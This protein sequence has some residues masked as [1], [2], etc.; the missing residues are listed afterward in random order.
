M[1]NEKI[2]TELMQV[3]SDLLFHDLICQE[4][5]R[6][7]EWIIM[8][9]LGCSY[10]D[11]HD[12]VKVGNVRLTRIDDKD[13]SKYIDLMLEYNNYK[14][15]FELNNSFRGIYTRNNIYAG[16]VLINNYKLNDDK[17]L[18]DNYYRKVVKIILINLNWHATEIMKENIPSKKEF[19]LPYNELDDKDY[20][21]KIININLDYYDKICYDDVDECDKFYKLL[22]V[23]SKEEMYNIMQKEKM[24][25]YYGNKIIELS[26]NPKYK[27]DIMYRM[28]QIIEDNVGIQTSYLEGKNVGILEGRK[29]GFEQGIEQGIEKN[30]KETI[31]NMLADKLPLETIS[32]YVGLSIKEIKSMML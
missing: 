30:K 32:K 14:V 5:K 20:L 7:I 9:V 12:K 21:V 8:H 1:T 17:E 25:S 3:K 16:T 28:D 23:K 31:K 6:I 27:E 18:H 11:V 24:L 15:V 26:S 2:M 19:D 22:T 4:D 29:E 10:N 13:R